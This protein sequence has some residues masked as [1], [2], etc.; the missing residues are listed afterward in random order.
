MKAAPTVGSKR[1]FVRHGK[2]SG[3]GACATALAVFF[4]QGL[5]PSYAGITVTAFGS[6]DAVPMRILEASGG[7]PTKIAAYL[8]GRTD[9]MVATVDPA[10]VRGAMWTVTGQQGAWTEGR[11][12]VVGA[13]ARVSYEVSYR[14]TASGLEAIVNDPADP[15]G[16]IHIDVPHDGTG[17]EPAVDPVSIL[18]ALILTCTLAD[19]YKQGRCLNDAKDTCGA[20]NVKCSSYTG[21]CGIGR[22]TRRCK[23][24]DGDCN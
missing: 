1:W 4:A 6:G 23:G 5:T 12:R 11:V 24:D 7:V 15:L 13:G 17:I 19:T 22:C 2:V 21:G 16:S 14:D 9:P 8:S 18:V 20:G 3:F 10:V